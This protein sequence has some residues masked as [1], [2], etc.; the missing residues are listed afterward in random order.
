MAHLA[1][2]RAIQWGMS[3][4]S[5]QAWK[6][7]A[8]SSLLFVVVFLGVYP[9]CN[10][11]TAHRT[12]TWALYY[13]WELGIPFVPIFIWAYLSMLLLW[14][15]QPLVLGPREI[16]R[17]TQR[18]L[19]ATLVSGLCF[20]ILPARLG[21][22]RQIPDGLFL[23][24]LYHGLF[25]LDHPHNLVPSLHVANS[26]LILFAFMSRATRPWLRVLWAAWLIL[27]AAST[28]L[29]HQHHLLDV[30]SGLGLA[31]LIHTY[32]P[33]SGPSLGQAK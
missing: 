19:T 14:P 5:L 33:L 6:A 18:M 2:S 3:P 27:I 4:R 25:R 13:S 30:I 15:I 32:L 22:P 21:F 23:A 26:A 7:Y 29:V 10:Y 17:L 28:L 1:R 24:S 8:A 12:T 9:A 11:L 16:W 31:A 20:L